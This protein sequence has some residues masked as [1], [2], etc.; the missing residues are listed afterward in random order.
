MSKGLALEFRLR[1]PEMYEEY[2]EKC[3]NKELQIGR[4]WVYDKPNRIDKK[5]LN[6]PTKNHYSHPSKLEY[7][8]AGLEY[9]REN[10]KA[11][12]ITSIAFPML[13]ARNGK[14]DYR[15]IYEIMKECLSDLPIDIEIYLS[16]SKSDIFTSNVKKLIM[17]A[18]TGMLMDMLDC[19]EELLTELREHTK[20]IQ[21]FPELLDFP[22]F[23]LERVQRIYD[24]GFQ[25]FSP[26]ILI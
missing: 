10:Y 7:I 26:R 21:S 12:K 1:I 16:H 18:P 3:F 11:D 5:V 15:D 2:R 8:M 17:D 23:T 4:Y 6:F 14:L 20:T 24:V 13:G 9:F 22:K 25:F 19:D